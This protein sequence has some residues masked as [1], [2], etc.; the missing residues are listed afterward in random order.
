VVL[1]Q[2]RVAGIR[3]RAQ[4]GHEDLVTLITTGGATLVA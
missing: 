1:H 3:A 2:G 4:T